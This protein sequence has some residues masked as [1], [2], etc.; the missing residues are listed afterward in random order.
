M[1]QKTEHFS[2]ITHTGKVRDNNEDAFLVESILQD[3]YILACVI[4]GVGGYEGG[5]VAAR[6]ARES[7][8]DHLKKPSEDLF[9]SIREAV[10]IANERI[11]AEKISSDRNTRMACVL[12]LALIDLTYNQF[13]YAHV[14]DTRLYLL[15]DYTLVKITRDDSFVGFLEDSKRLSEEEAMKHPKRNEINK[16]LGFDPNIGAISDYIETGISPFLPGDILLLCSDGL[17]D[18]VD[19]KK[20]TSILISKQK[21]PE[22]AKTLIDAANDAGGNDNITVVLIHNTNKR[23]VQEVTKPAVVKK[24]DSQIGNDD[25]EN[26]EDAPGIKKSNNN[27]GLIIILFIFCFGL[28]AALLWQLSK[29]KKQEPS[30]APQMQNQ[31]NAVELKLQN[32]INQGSNLILNDSVYGRSI[33]ISDVIHVEKDSL[34]INGNGIVLRSDSSY[35]DAAFVIGRNCKYVLL[36]NII[37]ENFE[38]AIIAQSKMVLLKNVKFTNCEVSIQYEYKFPQNRYVNG[39]IADTLS[40]TDSLAK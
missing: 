7:I 12:T 20:I 9:L 24:N 26:P 28:M 13:Y 8:L 27:R 18:M 23:A 22:K 38:K 30:P 6:L 4:D 5:E 25:Q 17:T 14:G 19:S 16:A 37:F 29:N 31:P 39:N 35:R 36:E 40:L 1:R 34:Y 11:Y 10:V 2:G 33:L 3:R 15:R 21:I 32:N